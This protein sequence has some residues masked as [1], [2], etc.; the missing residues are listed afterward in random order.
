M[1]LSGVLVLTLISCG[2]SYQGY[3][4]KPYSVRGRTYYP[5]GVHQAL[6][7]REVGL[8][9]WYDERRFFG[10]VG[11]KTALGEPYRAGA[12]AGAHKTLPLPCRVKVT[13]LDNG[14]SVKL[15]LNDRGPFVPGRILDVTKSVASKLGFREKGLARVHVEVISVGDG[16]FQV[17][18]KR[19]GRSSLFSLR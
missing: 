6:A 9:S 16:E 17:K 11:G 1:F 12:N 4:N 15:R 8:A 19:R 10:L 3:K 13:N 2:S 14:R 18:P 5:V 7:H